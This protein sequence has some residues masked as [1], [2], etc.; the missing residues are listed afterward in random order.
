MAFHHNI[1]HA[2]YYQIDC[3][4][5]L[6]ILKY[7]VWIV[8]KRADYAETGYGVQRESLTSSCSE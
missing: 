4:N 3:A 5:W 1:A 8:N 2:Q 7:L 6:H